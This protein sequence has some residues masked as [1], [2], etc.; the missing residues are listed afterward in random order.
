M[1]PRILRLGFHDC[2]KYTD[3]T[4]GC[5]GCLNWKGMNVDHRPIEDKG[6]AKP[7][8]DST[9]NNGLSWPLIQLEK[10]YKDVDYPDGAPSLGQSLYDS[11]KSRAD[12]WAFAAIVAVEYGIETTNLACD[13]MRDERIL[14]PSCIHDSGSDCKIQLQRDFVFQYGR[15]DCTAHHPT[16][17]YIATKSE[18]HA[19]PVANGE[20]TVN[21]FRDYFGFTGRE[22]VA[23]MGAH[24]FGK[25]HNH[26]SIFKYEWTSRGINLFNNDYYRGITGQPRWM[27]DDPGCRKVGDAFGNK[28]ETMWVAHSRKLTERG[29]PVFWV[30]RNHACPSLYN[31]RPLG[32]FEQKCVDE[33][34]P[35]MQCRADP[36]AGGSQP[37]TV[38]QDDGDVNTGCERFKAILVHDNVALN[39]DMGLYREFEV[40][41]GI[42]HGCPGL[43]HFNDSMASDAREAIWSKLP[44][45]GLAQPLCQKQR[46]EEPAGSTPMY[47][48]ME[49]YANDQ[50]AWI[51]DFVPAL[52]KMLANGYSTLTDAPDY[53]VNAYCP[54]YSLK[55]SEKD[56][57]VLCYESSAA[58]DAAA[59]ML[60]N[61]H[62]E[63]A[64]KVYQYNQDTGKI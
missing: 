9:D 6:K 60:G 18:V 64:G 50:T 4:G 30:H 37:R 53:H 12:L 27:I 59:F 26:I 41:D 63:L 58:E 54:L 2:L 46:R 21:F 16:R 1:A 11:G 55:T 31:S 7:N 51:N 8:I 43:E 29:G 38:I 57:Y 20:V 22:T 3:G 49:E 45:Q 62:G 34:A 15:T 24:T 25:L 61:K 10:V 40:S 28:P 56:K 19:N 48:I 23:I 47:Q 33:A 39:S 13:N 42:I 17:T 5:D 32:V 36:P 35:G 44:G 14:K 52:E